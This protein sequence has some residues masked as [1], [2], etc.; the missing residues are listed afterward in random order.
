MAPGAPPFATSRRR[1]VE[2]VTHVVLHTVIRTL[3]GSLD[4]ITDPDDPDGE[5]IWATGMAAHALRLCGGVHPDAE[6]LVIGSGSDR[7][8]SWLAT[9]VR[10]VFVAL[11]PVDRRSPARRVCHQTIADAFAAHDDATLS[12]VVFSP[13]ARLD[14]VVLD[15]ASRVLAPGGTLSV[16]ANVGDAHGELIDRVEPGRPWR[17]VAPFEDRRS[18]ATANAGVTGDLVHLTLMKDL[19]DGRPSAVGTIGRHPEPPASEMARRLASTM[20]DKITLVDGGARFGFSNDWTALS[21][22]ARL[23][24]FE[25]DEDECIRLAQEYKG[26]VDATL[27]AMGLGSVRETASFHVTKAPWG[28]SRLAPNREGTTHIT[29]Q[30]GSEVRSVV[31]VEFI[32]LDDWCSANAVGRVDGIK[33]DVEGA[34]LD[35]LRGASRQLRHVRALELEV[36]FSA[37]NVG[38]PLFGDIAAHLQSRGFALW[39]F[40]NLVHYGLKDLRVQP[41]VT[42]SHFFD[43]EART[44]S[45]PDSQMNWCDALFVARDAFDESSLDWTQRVRD[46]VVFQTMDLPGLSSHA[47]E[48]LLELDIPE[49]VRDIAVEW[50][51][52]LAAEAGA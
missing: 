52:A 13:A 7:L 51:D 35:I 22:H 33:L 18:R 6:I 3:A 44:Y 5:A 27:V 19:A 32:P 41:S 49:A 25:P 28:A 21:P 20:S 24:G 17:L 37:L 15:E 48:R 29:Y 31:D 8:V 43:N 14:E 39:R 2:D 50:L 12:A 40:R 42:V 9:Q 46:A 16:A 11:D 45:A 30:P 47:L 4:G 36:K 23:I 34:E 38:Q 26:R 10:R 1:N